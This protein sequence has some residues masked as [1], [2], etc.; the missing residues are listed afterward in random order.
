MKIYNEMA[1][2]LED[3]AASKTKVYKWAR[4]FKLGRTNVEN[5]TSSGRPK[6]AITPDIIQNISCTVL[7]DWQLRVD[8][9][10]ESMRISYECVYHTLLKILI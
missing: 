6:S 4:E 5:D 10:V 9:I 2:V 7:E 3:A 1:C 8:D